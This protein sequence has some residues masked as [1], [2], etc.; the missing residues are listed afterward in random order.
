M[1]LICPNCDAQYEVDDSAIPDAG[2]DVQCSNCGHTWFQ[3][4]VDFDADIEAETALF[5][6]PEPAQ[7]KSDANPVAPPATPP[8]G[9]PPSAASPS[10]A[11][12]TATRQDQPAL[13]AAALPGLNDLSAGSTP[14]HAAADGPSAAD[15]TPN[16]E[17]KGDAP[18]EPAAEPHAGPTVGPADGPTLVQ[19]RGLDESVLAVLREEAER[20]AA[21]RRSETPRALETQTDLGLVETTGSPAATRGSRAL[22]APL[23]GLE[24]AVEITERPASRRDLLPDIEE[25]NSTLRASSENRTGEAQGDT[26]SSLPVPAS[27]N[28]FRSGFSLML[29]LAVGLTTAYVAAPR[30]VA[31]LPATEPAMRS[32]VAAVDSVRL[33][34]DAG[35]RSATDSLKSLTGSDDS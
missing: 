9:A 25:I 15:T 14:Q 26:P 13:D 12:P 11:L 24:P 17:T 32:Y 23:R 34:L 31:H 27:G 6:T 4:P 18:V 10:G 33:W 20:E 16:P 22:A 21:V 29:L 35:L 5:G 8:S 7:G 2:R 19:R 3:M 1:R 30:I 28:G